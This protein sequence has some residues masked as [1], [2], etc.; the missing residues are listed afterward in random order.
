[1]CLAN[2]SVAK[3]ASI[4]QAPCCGATVCCI[5]QSLDPNRTFHCDGNYVCAQILVAYKIMCAPTFCIHSYRSIRLSSGD[6]TNSSNKSY[7]LSVDTMQFESTGHFDNDMV[8]TRLSSQRVH[9][10]VKRDYTKCNSLHWAI[11]AD[12]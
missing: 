11:T 2:G 3:T 5:H 6:L 8:R 10:W 9:E 12:V 1:M 4:I 7:I